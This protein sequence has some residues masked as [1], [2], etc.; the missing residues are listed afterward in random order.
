[1]L[2]YL[3]VGLFL[4]IAEY[5]GAQCHRLP[6]MTCDDPIGPAVAT[7][8]VTV[9]ATSRKRTCLTHLTVVSNSTFTVTVTDG[10]AGTAI[11][12]VGVLSANAGYTD[13]WPIEKPL[14]GT[15][16]KQLGIAVDNGTHKINYDGYVY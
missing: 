5:A 10:Y 4:F 13:D 7:S 14:C 9:S 16:G 2:R 8:S 3:F 11:W 12:A 15:P 6:N 1:M